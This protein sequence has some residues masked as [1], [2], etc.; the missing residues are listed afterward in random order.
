MYDAVKQCSIISYQIKSVAAVSLRLL[1][2]RTRRASNRRQ[3]LC[4]LTS[5]VFASVFE[6][7]TPENTVDSLV[8]VFLCPLVTPY[9]SQTTAG[10]LPWWFLCG[11]RRQ[12]SIQHSTG[13]VSLR[14][15]R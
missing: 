2:L 8:D 14:L 10:V 15:C 4:P 12:L 6:V 5:V 9:A 1:Q 7:S 11:R 3:K 13:P